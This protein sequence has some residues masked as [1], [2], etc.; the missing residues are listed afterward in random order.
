[1][2]PHV[3]Y[4]AHKR[5]VAALA[6]ARAKIPSV[7]MDKT[8]DYVSKR[9]GEHV[10]YSFA[11]L[12]SISKTVTQPLSEHGLV[13]ECVFNGDVIVVLLSHEDGGIH[14]S[15]LPLPNEGDIK[16]L[17]TQITMRRRYLTTQLIAIVADE[18]TGERDIAEP[19]KAGGQ[20]RA[21]AGQQRRTAA[22]VG[23]RGRPPAGEQQGTLGAEQ[24][25]N[26]ANELLAKLPDEV[27]DKLREQY[28][29]PVELLRRTT[30][31]INRRNAAKARGETPAGGDAPET[32]QDPPGDDAP[33]ESTA[34]SQHGQP[35]SDA[36]VEK[37]IKDGMRAL[38]L[39][40][41]EQATLRNQFRENPRGLLQHIKAL[42]NA[43]RG[44]DG[45]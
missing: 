17:A 4:E 8:V 35:L 13:L 27:A 34:V 6:K 19:K 9:T 23:G 30:D 44:Q 43:E 36:A 7:P 38:K 33:A 42:Y 22:P 20:R 40:T 39:S 45:S 24:L 25:A 31:E 12:D 21:P 1:M 11:S 5:L 15:W 16:D 26:R 28:K 3:E 14:L 10:H 18:D 2:P 37:H 41:E 32:A 29:D